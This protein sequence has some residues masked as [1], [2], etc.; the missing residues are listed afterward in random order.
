VPRR[1][2]QPPAYQAVEGVEGVEG[3]EGLGDEDLDGAPLAHPD[4]VDRGVPGRRHGVAPAL[5]AGAG[6]YADD[7]RAFRS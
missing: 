5:L 6:M 1:Q 3:G 2:Q 7:R 4:L